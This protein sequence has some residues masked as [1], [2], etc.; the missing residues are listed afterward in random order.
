MKQKVVALLQQA[1]E[2]LIEQSVL[3]SDWI[4]EISVERTRDAQHGDFASNLA[5]RKPNIHEKMLEGDRAFSRAFGQKMC[6]GLGDDSGQHARFRMD[7]YRL[8]R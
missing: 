8:P 7:V 6:R 3:Q 1:V 4:P 5:G 2:E